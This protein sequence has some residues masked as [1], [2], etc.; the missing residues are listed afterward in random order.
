V[1]HTGQFSNQL[2]KNFKKIYELKAVIPVLMLQP[3]A[4]PKGLKVA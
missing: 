2:L 3:V 1:T 4:I